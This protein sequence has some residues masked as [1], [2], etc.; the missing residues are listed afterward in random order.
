[1]FHARPQTGM[2][3]SNQTMRPCFSTADCAMVR[4]ENVCH[5]TVERSQK[6]ICRWRKERKTSVDVLMYSCMRVCVCVCACQGQ[7]PKN[8]NNIPTRR[9]RSQRKPA[10]CSSNREPKPKDACVNGFWPLLKRRLHVLQQSIKGV[11]KE[12]SFLSFS[13]SDSAFSPRINRTEM[14][15]ER[16]LKYSLFP[17]KMMA[18]VDGN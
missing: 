10:R 16:V 14:F 7:P 4:E 2:R 5:C 3:V 8:N 15:V 6:C 13:R 18:R 17:M 1:M 11:S 12:E 9:K